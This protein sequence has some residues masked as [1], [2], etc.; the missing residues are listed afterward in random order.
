MKNVK[1]PATQEPSPENPSLRTVPVKIH[2]KEC[3]Q[4]GENEWVVL[5]ESRELTKEEQ[6]S[7]MSLFPNLYENA[8]KLLSQ[9]L[10]LQAV[11]C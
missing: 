11:I 10:L 8:D 5:I 9:E 2:A 6:N 4:V 3:K 7:L 1:V